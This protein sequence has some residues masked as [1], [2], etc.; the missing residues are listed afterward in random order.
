MRCQIKNNFDRGGKSSGNDAAAKQQLEE[1]AVEAE[2]RIASE[3]PPPPPDPPVQTVPPSSTNSRRRGAVPSSQRTLAPTPDHPVDIVL[4][5]S[6]NVD[7][8]NTTIPAI[9]QASPQDRS[10]PKI[11]PAHQVVKSGAPN[12]EILVAGR[13]PQAG[14]VQPIVTAT[15]TQPSTYTPVEDRMRVTGGLRDSIS[16]L[17]SKRP[18]SI[19][20]QDRHIQDQPPK[21][22]NLTFE[23]FTHELQQQEQQRVM[24]GNDSQQGYDYRQTSAINHPGYT[25]SSARTVSNPDENDR[26]RGRA[27]TPEQYH[28]G[29]ESYGGLQYTQGI[30]P[31]ASSS[32][33]GSMATVMGTS[34]SLLGSPGQ[35]LHGDLSR[36]QSVATTAPDTSRPPAAP[37]QKRSNIMSLLNDDPPEEKKVVVPVETRHIPHPRHNS[38]MT[39]TSMYQ[40]PT[41][42]SYLRRD[43][44]DPIRESHV[45]RGYA[46]PSYGSPIV[47]TQGYNGPPSQTFTHPH[48]HQQHIPHVREQ[49]Q[50]SYFAE[51]P[52]SHEQSRTLYSHQ[53]TAASPPAA[54]PPQPPQ[55]N[56]QQSYHHQIRSNYEAPSHTHIGSTSSHSRTTS[57]SMHPNPPTTGPGQA[58]APSPY[59]AIRPSNMQSMSH[60]PPIPSP[61]HPIYHPGN[62]GPPSMSGNSRA[63]TAYPGQ[64]S[65]DHR[66]IEDHSG[67]RRYGTPTQTPPN[68]GGYGYAPPQ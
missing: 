52:R 25:S 9:S 27:P 51:L 66:R 34:S 12:P 35:R 43:V 15:Q 45:P 32:H 63:A 41:Q 64:L 28:K 58:L 14:R 55:P 62:Q 21:R 22:Q 38:P 23:V 3:G 57:Y 37:V 59:A 67:I 54:Q 60:H 13:P 29:R 65:H 68:A 30:L 20:E 46:Q 31:P 1:Y 2:R 11:A 8:R 16:T 19:S 10:H 33:P 49:Y 18:R 7:S 36:P 40:T 56:Q 39:N 61:Q 26:Y 48:Q 17:Q 24:N 4:T 42:S 53:Q 5:G 47:Q 44:V 50:R 6:S